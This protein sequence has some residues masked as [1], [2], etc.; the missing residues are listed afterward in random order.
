M[1]FDLTRSEVCIRK[2][3]FSDTTEQSIEG[4]FLLPDYCPD[5][6]R[7]LKCSGSA[8]ILTKTVTSS[9]IMV[10][11]TVTVTLLY[12]DHDD[13]RIR[14]Y[15]TMTGFTKEIAARE[16]ICDGDICVLCGVDYLNCRLITPRKFDIHGAVSIRVTVFCNESP[17][18]PCASA[19]PHIQLKT[20][21]I[22]NT[23][24]LS[25]TERSVTINQEIEATDSLAGI[26]NVLRSE[27][28]PIFRE[29]R[30]VTGKA[31]VK[32]DLILRILFDD[33]RGQIKNYETTLAF[34][35]IMDAAGAEEDCICDVKT[36]LHALEL[37]TRTGMDGECKSLSL[38]ATVA[39][40]MTV[41]RTKKETVITDAYSTQYEI[42]PEMGEFL[43]R[44]RFQTLNESFAVSQRVDFPETVSEILDSHSEIRYQH[45]RMEEGMLIVTALMNCELL[46]INGEG[47]PLYLEKSFEFSQKFQLESDAENEPLELDPQMFCLATAFT[48]NGETGVDLRSEIQIFSPVFRLHSRTVLRNIGE[49]SEL[50]KEIDRNISLVVYFAHSGETVW[51]IARRYNT[52][53]EAIRSSN[54][55]RQE[56]LDNDQMLMIPV[57]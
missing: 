28:T 13:G 3:V 30:T 40:R 10:G 33:D 34:S 2:E 26:R 35:Q 7:I 5:I 8:K 31:I 12:L 16:P 6:A 41:S 46:A 21:E 9:G 15:Q 43:L 45:C 19:E 24:V 49:N 25:V 27:A 39:I 53:S 23:R 54:A 51:D 22:S 20:E 4:E 57:I 42:I 11:G 36:E 47:S 48:I 32:G 44:E 56:R 50:K 52:S 18:L 37:R 14:S 55:L 29:C 17:Q 1:S 38:S